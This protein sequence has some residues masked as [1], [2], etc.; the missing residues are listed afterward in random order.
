M[1][2]PEQI[3]ELGSTEPLDVEEQTPGETPDEVEQRAAEPGT[4]TDLDGDP[5]PDE[6]RI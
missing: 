6:G 4:R 2:E 5:R 1:L 3:D